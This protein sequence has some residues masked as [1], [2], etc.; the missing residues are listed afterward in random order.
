MQCEASM[1][2]LPK[3]CA[4]E[5]LHYWKIY[6]N[7]LIYEIDFRNLNYYKNSG[8]KYLILNL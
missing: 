8:K 5:K 3:T 6:G 1:Q 7:L 4:S 2:S